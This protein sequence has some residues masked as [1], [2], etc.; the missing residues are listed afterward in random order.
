MTDEQETEQEV[1]E[2]SHFT[3]NLLIGVGAALA[4]LFLYRR[5]QQPKKVKVEATMKLSTNFTVGEFLVSS[6]APELKEYEF[7][8]GELGNL[9]RTA[10]HLQILRT[11][12]G[13]AIIISSGGRPETFKIKSG[14]YKGLT[15]VEMLEEKGFSPATFSQHMDFSAADFTTVNKN[16]LLKIYDMILAWE[17]DSMASS[18]VTQAILYIQNGVPSFIHLGVHSDLNNFEKII[19]NNK[20]LLAKVTV[21]MDNEG[22]MRRNTKFYKYTPDGLDRLLKV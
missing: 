7:V 1:V 8:E 6:E 10:G 18:A 12:Y 13:E 11:G 22:K 19:G 4:G 9:K 16:G 3:R 2:E 17:K 21:V 5:T 20:Y 14:K 15:L